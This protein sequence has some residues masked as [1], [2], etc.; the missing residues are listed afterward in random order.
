MTRALAVILILAAG[1]ASAADRS[2]VDLGPVGPTPECLSR[3]GRVLST[4]L[5]IAPKMT[6]WSATARSGMIEAQIVCFPVR[7]ILFVYGSEEKT[8]NRLT[9]RLAE[10]WRRQP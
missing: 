5:N 1:A 10:A 9:Q 8:R 3:A 2:D 7:V 4:V 6:A